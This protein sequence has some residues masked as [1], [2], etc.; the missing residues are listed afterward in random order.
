M[1]SGGLPWIEG[2]QGRHEEARY[3]ATFCPWERIM[4]KLLPSAQKMKLLDFSEPSA[5]V[6]ASCWGG[7]L[8]CEGSSLD[9]PSRKFLNTWAQVEN[10]SISKLSAPSVTH[11]RIVDPPSFSSFSDF[12]GITWE[13]LIF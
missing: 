3:L 12:R 7:R 8:S 9:Q 5:S 10:V 4:V 2:V 6:T 11:N 1:E 13:N